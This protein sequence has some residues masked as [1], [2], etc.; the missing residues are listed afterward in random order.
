MAPFVPRP[1]AM[2]KKVQLAEGCRSRGITHRAFYSRGGRSYQ[3]IIAPTPKP[4]SKNMGVRR[5]S[6]SRSD[7]P[8]MLL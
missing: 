6:A 4:R 7:L 5:K 8:M 3:I 2:T 1:R